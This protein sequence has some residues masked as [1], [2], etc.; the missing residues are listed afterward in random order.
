MKTCYPFSSLEVSPFLGSCVV[1]FQPYWW[2]LSLI[3]ALLL[4]AKSLSCFIRVPDSK[5][6]ESSVCC[7]ISIC[8]SC[9]VNG[10][11]QAEK[12]RGFFKSSR[13]WAGPSTWWKLWSWSYTHAQTA[14]AVVAA[15]ETRMSDLHIR[16]WVSLSL[17]FS[18]Q[19]MKI[20]QNW[21]TI[22]Q[23][24]YTEW[25]YIC[26]GVPRW[27][28]AVATPESIMCASGMAWKRSGGNPHELWLLEMSHCN[29][30]THVLD[31]WTEYI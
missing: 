29:L 15:R 8:S 13:G 3:H 27:L 14:L 19:C 10:L 6:P 2:V 5:Q 31:I 24:R 25:K 23:K 12:C 9:L 7:L 28:R 4:P 22:N 30:L 17:Q 20:N 16:E 21:T 1:F 18:A 26:L 11:I